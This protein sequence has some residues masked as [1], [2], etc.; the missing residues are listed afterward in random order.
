MAMMKKAFFL[1]FISVLMISL[2][3]MVFSTNLAVKVPEASDTSWAKVDTIDRFTRD[4]KSVYLEKALQAA[5]ISAFRSM[6]AYMAAN[7]SKNMSDLSANFT[8][9]VL[10]GTLGGVPQPGMQNN[11]LA[12]WSRRM[13]NLSYEHLRIK[14]N[15]TYG[16]FKLM[17][18]NPWVV[19]VQ[20]EFFLRTSKKDV[21]YRIDETVRVN[22]SIVGLP[23]PL[24]AKHG[25]SRVVKP[26]NIT[27]WTI[28][29]ALLHLQNGWF[30][31]NTNNSAP[32]YLMRFSNNL[33]NSTCCGIES[34]VNGSVGEYNRSYV[35][36]KFWNGTDDKCVLGWNVDPVFVV[37][38]L[39]DTAVGGFGNFRL[40]GEDFKAYTNLT[41]SS[42]A[43]NR[44]YS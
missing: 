2:F 15:L 34:L 32:S 26:T 30:R 37:P 35:D 3:I 14:S 16:S 17:Q 40:E 13:E 33:T 41:S 42:M 18:T 9:L 1:T 21:N 38:G 6:A 12:N 27:N 24:F 31:R 39:S 10:F 8:E 36:Y 4:L 44:C 7:P 23:D 11:T 43:D 25:Q 5:S 20:A 19:T 28:D 29:N 22:V